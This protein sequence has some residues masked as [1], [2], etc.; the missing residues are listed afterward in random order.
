MPGRLHTACPLL[1]FLQGQLSGRGLQQRVCH[2]PRYGM[3]WHGGLALA[4]WPE[5]QSASAVVKAGGGGVRSESYLKAKTSAMHACQF[6]GC[7]TKSLAV[8]AAHA[9]AP[10]ARAPVWAAHAGPPAS[11]ALCNESQRHM[12]QN[13]DN[14][15]LCGVDRQGLRLIRA[16]RLTSSSTLLRTRSRVSKTETLISKKGKGSAA[17]VVVEGPLERSV[18][19]LWS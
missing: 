6:Y 10:V 1:S 2:T 11:R 15:Q 3:R 4:L 7:R 16:G 13:Q 9:G 8:W 17:T 12:T 18:Q 19:H 14:G 5:I